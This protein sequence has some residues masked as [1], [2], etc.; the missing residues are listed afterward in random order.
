MSNE[1][2][3]RVT[4]QPTCHEY[5]QKLTELYL[6]LQEAK[7]ENERLG[8]EQEILNTENKIEKLLYARAKHKLVQSTSV[9]KLVQS[10]SV[11]KLVQSINTQTC[12]DYK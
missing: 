5:R 10:T 11:H 4:G 1:T 9:H 3:R 7:T 2:F 8:I 6:E 12:K